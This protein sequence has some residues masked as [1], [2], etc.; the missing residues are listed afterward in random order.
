MEDCD[1]STDFLPGTGIWLLADWSFETAIDDSLSSTRDITFS[2]TS[3][4]LSFLHRHSP[5]AFRFRRGIAHES[6]LHQ[7][8][9]LDTLM[10]DRPLR[11][12]LPCRGLPVRVVFRT[13]RVERLLPRVIQ[14]TFPGGS[15]TPDRA[16]HVSVQIRLDSLEPT[17]GYQRPV[18]QLP[19]APHFRGCSWDSPLRGTRKQ[20]RIKH[21]VYQNKFSLTEC[22]SGIRHAR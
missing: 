18:S 22:R 16:R 1:L 9:H 13:N 6:V 15:F 10:F 20:S 5:R 12:T 17:V 19:S 7:I 4:W 3:P 2:T 14:I 8:G 21:N 11:R